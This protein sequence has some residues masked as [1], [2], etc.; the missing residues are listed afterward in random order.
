MGYSSDS[1]KSC[2]SCQWLIDQRLRSLVPQPLME[3]AQSWLI[4]YCPPSERLL[5]GSVRLFPRVS[6]IFIWL[7]DICSYPL[8]KH[9]APTP[10]KEKKRKKKGKRKTK[11]TERLILIG[12]GTK[13]AEHFQW[14]HLSQAKTDRPNQWNL[15][16]IFSFINYRLARSNFIHIIVSQ[17]IM[18]YSFQ[19]CLR[20]MFSL[21][22]SAHNQHTRESVS[23]THLRAHETA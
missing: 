16:C 15:I 6:S 4:C 12:H 19:C 2:R 23:Y 3:H 1:R 18:F 10:E 22:E 14:K 8:F 9:T 20:K 7:C 11:E 17:C 13:R 5:V 21:N